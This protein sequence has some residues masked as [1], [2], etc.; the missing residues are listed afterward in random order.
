MGH[1][2]KVLLQFCKDYFGKYA[3][4]KKDIHTVISQLEREGE[5]KA[6]H[7]ILD[8]RRWDDLT[9]EFAQHIMSAQEGGSELKTWG[10]ILGAL[11]AARVE[12]KVLVEARYLLG[13]GG[14]GK[15]PDPGDSGA[16]AERRQSR[17]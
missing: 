17:Q 11:K 9:S 7:E 1:V 14:R 5:V 8:H 10:L 2:L 15:T 6:P 12:G 13:L 4:S 3:P 16:G